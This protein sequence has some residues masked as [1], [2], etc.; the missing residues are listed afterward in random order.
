M[1]NKFILSILGALALATIQTANAVTFVDVS[2]LGT[3]I[4]DNFVDEDGQPFATANGTE[5][6]V[7]KTS[8]RWT[9]DKVYL[10]TQN[11]IIDTGV[12]LFIEPGTLIRFE[13]NV[14]SGASNS[15][16]ADPGALVVARGA[17]LI[18]CGTA[19]AP[20]ICTSIDDP[21]VPGGIYTIP[22]VRNR[23]EQGNTEYPLAYKELRAVGSYTV[24]SGNAN[25]T[26]EFTVSDTGAYPADF[27]GVISY[28]S[29][30]G[31]GPSMWANSGLWGGL[32]FCGEAN[33]AGPSPSTANARTAAAA[34]GA[35]LYP[36][37][38][39][40]SFGYY[41]LGG[42]NNDASD[43]GIVRFLSN[44]YGGFNINNNS[45]LNAFS[46]YG[47]GFNTVMEFLEDWCNKDDSY[48]F[49]GGCNTIKYVVSAFC[50]DDGLDTDAGWV[51]NAQFLLQI[52]NPIDNSSGAVGTSRLSGDGGDN[53]SENDG[54]EDSLAR[55]LS[56]ATIANCTFIGRGY[57]ASKLANQCGPQV[58]LEGSQK[59]FNNVI[60]DAAGG[61]LALTAVTDMYTNTTASSNGYD[62]SG[63]NVLNE[64][65]IAN[66]RP[67]GEVK[68]N[69]WWRCGLGYTPNSRNI[70]TSYTLAQV[71]TNSKIA[72]LAQLG[73]G[74]NSRAGSG[75]MSSA[76]VIALF[77]NNVTNLSTT[78]HTTLANDNIVNYDPGFTV[79]LAGRIT[80][81]TLSFIPTNS[82]AKNGGFAMNLDRAPQLAYLTEATHVGAVRDNPWYAGW[83]M[84]SQSGILKSSDRNPIRSD[85]SL[86]VSGSNILVKFDTQNLVKY[87]VE[88]ST[89]NKVYSQ[90]ATVTGNGSQ[91]TYTNGAVSSAPTFFRV[92]A[93]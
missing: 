3:G 88:R 6:S 84:L 91:A 57:G 68:G 14:R 89:D 32:V 30:V 74:D 11:T 83:T 41:A 35:G 75:S 56:V 24:T 48:E 52:Q 16:P 70:T 80:Q 20:I 8:Q 71:T 76:G 50:G 69:I 67:F 22:P 47:V 58:K 62:D 44:R 31:T 54:P 51:G 23:K 2:T 7:I 66:G 65:D 73:F 17:T 90:V 49:W 93:F 26:G 72:T 25:L 15:N 18:A 86:S 1:K 63:K 60:Q 36:V 21:N 33:I 78:T 53:L 37:E 45:E 27:P 39:M 4:V 79:P 82:L 5:A 85:A 38:G 9:R 81:D 55:P 29:T 42:G 19:E 87:S 34:T 59:F 43:S 28:T 77:G 92:I 46:C 10:I 40:A 13:E 61:G 64:N 12:T